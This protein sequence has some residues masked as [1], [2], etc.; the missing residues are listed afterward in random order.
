MTA[1]LKTNSEIIRRL[2]SNQTYETCKFI[3]SISDEKKINNLLNISLHARSDMHAHK[4]QFIEKNGDIR[5]VAL[6]NEI[7]IV[8]K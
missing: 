4:G 6:R 3:R 1:A 7:R 8:R 2:L 5:S